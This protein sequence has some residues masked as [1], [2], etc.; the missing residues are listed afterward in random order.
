MSENVRVKET[1]GPFERANRSAPKMR[2]F[3]FR[4][5]SSSMVMCDGCG[6]PFNDT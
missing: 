1:L 3:P 5:C 4:L 6:D 2:T